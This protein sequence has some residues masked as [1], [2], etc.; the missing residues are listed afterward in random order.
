MPGGLPDSRRGM[1]VRLPAWS[2]CAVA[3]APPCA[4]ARPCWRACSCSPRCSRPCCCAATRPPRGCRSCRRRPGPIRRRCPTR[5]PTTPRA[6]RTSCAGPP[7]ARATCSTPGPPAAR[8]RPPHA[9]PAGALRSSAPRRRPASTRISWKASCSSRAPAGRTRR[10]VTWRAPSAS[11]RSWPRRARACWA[12]ASTWP[13]AAASG[14]GSSVRYAPGGPPKRRG[15]SASGAPSTSAS[16]RSSRSPAARA[17]V[18]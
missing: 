6:R 3:P 18:R 4:L 2:G 12:C 9:S 1:H 7:P 5:S 13:G 11:R 16:T 15:W 10:R 17:I 8:R 14:A